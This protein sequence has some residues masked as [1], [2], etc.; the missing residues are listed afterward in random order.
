MSTHCNEEEMPVT[1]QQQAEQEMWDAAAS[2]DRAPRVYAYSVYVNA[3]GA[4]C[5][6]TDDLD[7]ATTR[8]AAVD[9]YVVNRFEQRIYPVARPDY[10]PHID[11]PE[12]YSDGRPI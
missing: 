10:D 12:R 8:A 7:E 5:M 11:H 4:R 1:H 2:S 6:S 9:G 3:T